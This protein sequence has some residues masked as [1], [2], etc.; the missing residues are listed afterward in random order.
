MRIEN[1]TEELVDLK[2]NKLYYFRVGIEVVAAQVTSIDHSV[3]DNIVKVKLKNVHNKE[4]YIIETNAGINNTTRYIYDDY[5][6]AH[7]TLIETLRQ[8]IKTQPRDFPR[9]GLKAEY[10]KELLKYYKII[11]PELFV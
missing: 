8:Y 10:Y 4:T 1:T 3:L 7:V 6:E 9:S 11:F 5:Q 2:S